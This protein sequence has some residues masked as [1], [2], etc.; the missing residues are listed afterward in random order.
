MTEKT[1]NGMIFENFFKKIRDDSL[2]EGI[3]DR[4]IELIEENPTQNTL[5]NL[6][7]SGEDETS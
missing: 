7:K 6:L 5:E 3:K 2:F 1:V 4:L